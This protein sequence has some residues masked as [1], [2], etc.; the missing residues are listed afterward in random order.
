MAAGRGARGVH[1]RRLDEDDERA[2]RDLPGGDGPLGGGDPAER[3]AQVDGAGPGE[4]RVAPG[5]RPGER[6]VHL[7]DPGAVAEPR[8]AV[9]GAGGQPVAG[10]RDELAGGDVEQGRPR[11]REVAERRGRARP[12]TTSPPRPRAPPRARRRVAAIPRRP[13][14]SRPRARPSRA[15]GRTRR[16]P[17]TRG[18]RSRGRR[19]RRGAPGAGSSRNAASQRRRPSAAPRARTGQRRG[20]ARRARAA[21]DPGHQRARHR[22]RAAR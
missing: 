4:V 18:G 19:A 12:V 21:Q 10:E 9:P 1:D 17:G 20:V 5:D 2:A 13:R 14:A 15:R 16:S 6:P 22:V 8:Q 7:A 11:R 3:P